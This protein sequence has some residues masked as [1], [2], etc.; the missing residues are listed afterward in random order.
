[1]TTQSLAVSPV[2]INVFE[3]TIGNV[4]QLVV[5]A[6]DLHGFLQVGKHFASWIQER[7]GKYEF[8][9]NEDFLAISQN[10]EIGHG[11]GKLE[12]HIALDMA[13]EL[14]MVENNDKGREARRYFIAMEKQALAALNAQTPAL[15][16]ITHQHY[17][18]L[19]Q[20]VRSLKMVFRQHE[21]A[22]WWA[23]KELRELTGAEQ[24]NKMP[25]IWFNEAK[26]HLQG[27]H[28][29][30]HA[31][32]RLVIKAEQAFFKGDA[33]AVPPEMQKMF[34]DAQKRLGY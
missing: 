24:I 1:M 5:N 30:A 6:R 16:C 11:R 18:E 27:L 9:E 17:E 26:K 3:G 4:R 32:N 19:A 34:D 2:L 20:I 28:D 13:K 10:R 7:I 15:E 23:W 31:F 12:Y 8:V 21:S 25:L 14:S 33:N 22:S 29:R